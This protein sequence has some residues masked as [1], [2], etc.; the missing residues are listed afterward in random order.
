MPGFANFLREVSE[1]LL[2]IC[3]I[4]EALH[5][6]LPRRLRLPRSS[7]CIEKANQVW[8]HLD[9][10]DVD[11]AFCNLLNNQIE[12]Y[13]YGRFGQLAG[14]PI[15]ELLDNPYGGQS[16]FAS[17]RRDHV[18]NLVEADHPVGFVVEALKV[19]KDSP[20]M[21]EANRRGVKRLRTA[22]KRLYP[23]RHELRA[24]RK[25]R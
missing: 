25:E 18:G 8:E 21:R 10:V 12:D 4:V 9:D 13:L 1:E 19:C 6:A 15:G 24:K 3:D 5:G 22:R 17:R 16:L 14:A 23:R 7:L 2:E 11:A 20:L